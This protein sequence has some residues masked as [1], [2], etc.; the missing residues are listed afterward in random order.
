MEHQR[1]DG[2]WTYGTGKYHQWID[3]FHTGYNLECLHDYIKFSGDE[4][5]HSNLEKGWDY[6]I[7]TFF[8]Q[9]NLLGYYSHKRYPIDINNILYFC[10]TEAI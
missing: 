5:Y 4:R 7:N 3:N 1:E 10:Y 6:Y 8:K 9:P 2:S